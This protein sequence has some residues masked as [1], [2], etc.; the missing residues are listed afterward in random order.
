MN[1]VYESSIGSRSQNNGETTGR[2]SGGSRVKREGQRT[3][4]SPVDVF[5][6]RT[7]T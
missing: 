1:G 6:V 2:A 4:P 3:A 5:L 7:L